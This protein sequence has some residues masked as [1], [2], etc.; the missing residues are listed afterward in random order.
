[1]TEQQAAEF[2][3]T[4]RET[5]DQYLVVASERGFT[6]RKQLLDLIDSYSQREEQITWIRENCSPDWK[7]YLDSIIVSQEPD[8]QPADAGGG[9]DADVQL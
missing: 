6:K 2:A 8:G 1:V 5:L 4:V 7:T 9:Q 3:L